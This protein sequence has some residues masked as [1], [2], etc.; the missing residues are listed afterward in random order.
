MLVPNYEWVDV[1]P[2]FDKLFDG[3]VRFHHC[4]GTMTYTVET[5]S[6]ELH[7]MNERVFTDF[8]N[9]KRAY[10]PKNIFAIFST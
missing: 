7:P 2:Q 1:D 10:L 3:S 8:I 5:N 9:D 4:I 6:Y